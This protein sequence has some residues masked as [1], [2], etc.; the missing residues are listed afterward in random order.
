MKIKENDIFL[1]VAAQQSAV[2]REIRW[3][4]GQRPAMHIGEI[5]MRL[6]LAE[7]VVRAGLQNMS[8]CGEVELLRPVD[9]RS[10]ESDFFRLCEADSRHEV[11]REIGRIAHA[12]KPDDYVLAGIVG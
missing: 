3:T 1:S 4:L 2:T 7:G 6:G 8:D 5:C 9:Y 12:S 10:G 11:Y